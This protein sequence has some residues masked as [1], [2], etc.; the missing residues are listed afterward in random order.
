[1]RR[2]R[3][4]KTKSGGSLYLPAQSLPTH[5]HLIGATGTGKSTLIIRLLTRM[6]LSIIPTTIFVI[7]PLGGLAEALLD[8]IAHPTRCT[9]YVRSRLVYIKPA[10]T[11]FVMPFNPL[12]FYDEHDLYY[13]TGRTSDVMLRS[14]RSTD[15][16]LMLRLRRWL[17]NCFYSMGALGYPPAVAQFLLR[18]GTEPHEQLLRQIPP[19]LQM[20]W[21]ELL[22]AGMRERLNML[23]ST[24]NRLSPFFTCPVLNHML[25]CPENYFDV[26]RFIRDKKI[27][28]VNLAPEGKIDPHI[29]HAIGGLMVNE[30]IQ[31]ARNLPRDVVNPTMLVLDEFQNFVGEDLYSAIPET[32]Q[33][34]L[35]LLLSHQSFSQLEQAD[36]DLQ[37]IVWQAR[38]RFMFANDAL[39]ADLLAHELG[40]L[41][42]DP[43]KLKDQILSFRQKKV[44]QELVRLNNYSAT[45]TTSTATDRSQSESQNKSTSYES[46]SPLDNRNLTSGTAKSTGAS[47]KEASSSGSSNG[48]SETFI[49]RLED[50][51]EVSSRDYYTF[52]EQVRIWGRE[53]REQLTGDC[54]VKIKDDNQVH[55]V[56]VERVRIPNTTQ[57]VE[58]KAKLIDENFG[59][60]GLFLPEAEVKQRWEHFVGLLA[61]G[62]SQPPLQQAVLE[63]RRVE[64]V[65]T[66]EDDSVFR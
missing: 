11:D 15:M 7:D 28:I 13:R 21:A 19:Q 37:G 44:G 10:K 33:L 23:D 36:V 58:L 54:F 49:D 3:I 65:T 61:S 43:K 29:A 57:L 56:R 40:S 59:N 4:G 9:D 17:Y 18:P 62:Q 47:H 31:T 48:W 20:D 24:R 51:Y 46:G 55:D 8:F 22:G 6:M 42:F 38:N 14:G 50:F 64:K 12:R 27:V 32:R 53:L 5:T 63:A 45:N 66:Q 60:R 25:A 34:G 41:Q 2:Y 16:T 26:E 35:Q 1:M 52:D 30:I 39:D